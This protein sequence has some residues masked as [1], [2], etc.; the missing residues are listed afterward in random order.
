LTE[1]P[2]RLRRENTVRNATKAIV[3]SFAAMA[4]LG[5]CNAS[6]QVPQ[7]MNYQVMLT[8]DGNEPLAD[9]AVT[10]VFRIYDDP[11]TGTQQWTETHNVTT[12]SIGVVSVILGETTPLPVARFDAAL[13]LEVQ[14]N[15]EILL[16]RRKLVSAPYALHAIDSDSAAGTADGYSL[17]ASDGSPVDAVYVEADGDVGMGTTAPVWDVHVH[18]TS[19]NAYGHFTTATTG[20][21]PTDGLVVG[22]EAAGAGYLWNY[23]D[24]NLVFGT[25]DQTMVVLD[26]A[27]AVKVGNSYSWSGRLDVYRLGVTPPQV[28]L[29]TDAY[30]GN[31][32]F[33]D[34]AG[35]T[36][37]LASADNSGTGGML[38]VSR[39]ATY[40]VD[41]G[42]DLNGNWAGAEQPA[43][44]VLGT[45]RMAGFYMGNS[46][47]ASVQLPADAIGDTEV[48][49]EPGVARNENLAS[50][51]LTGGV[52]I[53]T[54]RSVTVPAAGYV[55]AVGKCNILLTHYS[56]TATAAYVGLSSTTSIPAAQ[57]TFVQ[58]PPL[59]SNGTYAHVVAC[60][61]IFEVGA[62]GTYTFYF[63]ADESSGS[64]SVDTAVLTLAYFPTA[65]GT[66]ALAGREGDDDAEGRPLTPADIAAEQSEARE[67]NLARIEGELAEIRAEVEAMKAEAGTQ[68]APAVASPR[69][70]SAAQPAGVEELR[71]PT[72][73]A[74]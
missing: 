63:L 74:E 36:T 31:A 67:F 64:G 9:Q 34:E 62:A 71:G 6:A 15:G 1:N 60:S 41:E 49:D 4:V 22:A 32:T 66:V 72:A 56:G 17:D 51:A 7:M 5:S 24:A 50:F 12:N 23:E 38:H 13:W 40:N 30:G 39:D 54:S 57:Q 47:N 2:G 28:V 48:L 46:A 59:A 43:L 33:S 61:E 8:D 26:A 14:A 29:N 65:Y 69:A 27:D 52:D 53:I 55:L 16:P 37:V 35:N 42:I 70:E 45:D 19:G 58:L 68:A 10:L 18:R 3:L 21:G 73:A 25:N 20:T 11:S 44:R